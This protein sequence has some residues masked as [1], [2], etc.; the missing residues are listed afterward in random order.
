M[1]LAASSESERTDQC[2]NLQLD[3]TRDNE[4]DDLHRRLGENK[5]DFAGRDLSRWTLQLKSRSMTALLDDTS[6]AR[7]KGLSLRNRPLRILCQLQQ[8]RLTI[9][10]LN[11]A[12]LPSEGELDDG[13]SL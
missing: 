2:A 5:G 9:L 8:Y 4:I 12:T 3:S 13:S 7:S 1:N 10:I 11:V 6:I